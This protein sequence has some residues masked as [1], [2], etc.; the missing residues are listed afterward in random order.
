MFRFREFP[1]KLWI[2]SASGRAFTDD[3][4][5]YQDSGEEV[6]HHEQVFGVILGRRRLPDRR[7]RQ[8]RPVERVDV[9]SRQGRIELAVDVVDPIIRAE[10]KRVAQRK[11]EARIPMDQY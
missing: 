8:R 4:G 6:G 10:P 11:V 2:N 5:E 3:C 1:A 7:Q 9:L